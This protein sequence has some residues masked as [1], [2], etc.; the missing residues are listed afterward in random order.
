MAEIGLSDVV[1]GLRAE[2]ARAMTEGEDQQIQ[3]QAKSIEMEFQVGVQKKADG[4]AGLR[5]WVLE[6]GG[7]G[8]YATESIQRIRLSLEPAL[9]G[10]GSVKIAKGV[11]TSPLT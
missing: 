3:F 4:K 11:E 6:L 10:G 9:A 5:F 8:S 2:L 7:S 1:Q